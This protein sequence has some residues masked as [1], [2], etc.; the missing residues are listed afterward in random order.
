MI[1][2]ANENN[3]YKY[4]LTIIDTFSK[5]AWAVPIKNKTSEEVC[6]AVTKIF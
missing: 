2:F 5:Y 1:S 4:L 3:G 6:K